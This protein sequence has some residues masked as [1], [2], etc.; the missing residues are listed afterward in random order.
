ML[1]NQSNNNADLNESLLSDDFISSLGKTKNNNAPNVLSYDDDYQPLH[2]GQQN[3]AKTKTPVA[4]IYTNYDKH[5]TM[6]RW[7]RRTVNPVLT[8][9]PNY[10]IATGAGEVLNAITN[11][12]I[13]GLPEL[14]KSALS[15][16]T[17]YFNAYVFG[18]VVENIKGVTYIQ[19]WDARRDYLAW[20]AVIKNLAYTGVAAATG[21]FID[22]VAG[23]YL[24]NMVEDPRSNYYLKEYIKANIGWAVATGAN[25]FSKA[26]YVTHQ[27]EKAKANNNNNNYN[28][29]NSAGRCGIF[30]KAA[31]KVGGFFANLVKTDAGISNLPPTV[32]EASVS[33]MSATTRKNAGF[34]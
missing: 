34:K 16:S 24:D 9:L 5:A 30:G 18:P 6:K 31:N 10:L 26:V 14:A 20:Q 4:E 8:V 17:S 19:Y 21:V 27:Q 15:Y 22:H 13:A 33:E 32:I 28:S 23:G 3:Q 29:N 12:S 2:L 11:D 1:T 7:A 25:H